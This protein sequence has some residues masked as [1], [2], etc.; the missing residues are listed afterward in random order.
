MSTTK[1]NEHAI[2]DVAVRAES[3][4]LPRNLSYSATPI[5]SN[6]LLSAFAKTVHHQEG[7]VGISKRGFPIDLIYLSGYLWPVSGHFLFVV[8]A[9]LVLRLYLATKPSVT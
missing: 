7:L 9:A 8:T 4:T 3:W 2:L 5:W 6:V 1:C